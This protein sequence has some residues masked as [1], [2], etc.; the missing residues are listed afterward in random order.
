VQSTDRAV[1]AADSRGIVTYLNAAAEGMLGY[2]AAELVGQPLTRITP[3]RFHAAHRLSLQRMLSTGR[4]TLIGKTVTFE[5]LKKDGSEVSL[6]VSLATWP[7]RDGISFAAIL[8]EMTERRTNYLMAGQ[9]EGSDDRIITQSGE[10]R[11]QRDYS[12]PETEEPRRPQMRAY[13]PAREESVRRKP[14]HAP[15]IREERWRPLLEATPDAM[16]I[17]DERGQILL[18]NAQTERLFGYRPA[19]LVGQP[20]EV[21]LPAAARERHVQHRTAYCRA[22][23]PRLIGA[24]MELFGRRK[25]GSVFPVEVSLGPLVSGAG[26]LVLAAVRDISERKRLEAEV[27]SAHADLERRVQ[28]CSAELARSN[29]ELEQFTRVASH[30]LQEPLRAVASYAQLLARRY[31]GRLDGD[32]DK[33]IERITAAVGRM[34]QLIR[35]LLAYSRVDAVSRTLQPVAVDAVLQRVLDNLQAAIAESAAVITQDTLPTVLG[36]ESQLLQV[37]QNL[38]AN[39]LKFRSKEPPRIDVGVRLDGAE[40]IFSVSDNGIGLDP[41]FADRIFVIFQRLHARNEYPGTGVGLAICK[42]CV[43]AHGG[44]IWVE[45]QPGKGATFHFTIPVRGEPSAWAPQAAGV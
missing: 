34:Q 15:R 37:F 7:S 17:S 20:V 10:I 44:R 5:A 6:E 28:E 19:E 40:W 24:G 31:H 1:I 26:T 12:R 13:G 27:R 39:A 8:S 16:V 29:A 21:L 3:V 32:A 45:S 25:D 9:S 2:T 4:S 23:R 41:Q 42:K 36:D 35:D 33:F 22:P 30:D 38:I 14:E 18:A 43:E 11:W